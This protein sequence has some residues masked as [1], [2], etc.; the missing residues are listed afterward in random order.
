MNDNKNKVEP[1]DRQSP[2]AKYLR[3][4]KK[5]NL[6]GELIGAQP[7][8]EKCPKCDYGR[9]S[10]QKKNEAGEWYLICNNNPMCGHTQKS[11]NSSESKQ[12]QPDIEFSHPQDSGAGGIGDK[13][14]LI[15]HSFGSRGRN[16]PGKKSIDDDDIWSLFGTQGTVVDRRSYNFQDG[17]FTET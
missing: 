5:V 9:L 15:C 17:K 10:T 3:Q 4:R 13:E 2:T 14:P 11:G 6:V 8:F 12:A 1:I 16:R 7:P